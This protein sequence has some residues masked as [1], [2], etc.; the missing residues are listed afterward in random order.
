MIAYHRALDGRQ[1]KLF[2][3]ILG[4]S[5]LFFTTNFWDFSMLVSKT[6]FICILLSL[7]FFF[8][9]YVLILTNSYVQKIYIYFFFFGLKWWSI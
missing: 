4:G 5:M 9:I 7:F 3:L 1:E 2:V 8:N 6:F